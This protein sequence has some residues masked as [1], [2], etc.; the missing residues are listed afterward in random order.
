MGPATPGDTIETSTAI[1]H[2]GEAIGAD[3]LQEL[4]TAVAKTA[5][6]ERL[7]KRVT[8][9]LLAVG[10]LAVVVGL[11]G[12]FETARSLPLVAF[13]G[14]CAM[15]VLPLFLAW[16]VRNRAL[17]NAA[18]AEAAVDNRLLA[19]AVR[20]VEKKNLGPSLALSAT[21]SRAKAEAG[22]RLPRGA[23]G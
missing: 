19:A 3:L 23:G 21:L 5:S 17:L 22:G 10:A 6:R 16:G 2:A 8:I 1:M 18:A 9:A 14:L 13:G 12:G 20:L 11:L 7:R 4:A 15:P